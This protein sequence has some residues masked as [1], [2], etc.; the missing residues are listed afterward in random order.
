MQVTET[1]SDG[2][3][4][5]YSVVLPAADIETR[6]AERLTT[7]SKTMRLPGFRPG[8]VPM[9]IIRQ[10]FGTSVSAEVLEESVSEATRQVLT[11][12]GLRPAL[13]PKVEI[14]TDDPT[15]AIV[16]D[17]EFKV[18]MEL[19]PDI[20]LPDFGAIELT[21]KKVAVGE[22]MIAES[23]AAIAKSR[24]VLEDYTAEEIAERGGSL[25]GRTGD[26]LIV[27]YIGKIDG[28]AF[29]GGTANDAEI[30]LGG[31]GFI[32]GFVEQLEGVTVGE[33]RTINVT[34]PEGYSAT[35]LAGKPATFDITVKQIRKPVAAPLDDDFAMKIGYDTLE[36]LRED[37]RTRRQADFDGLSRMRVKRLLL[38]N[39]AG[40]VTFPLPPTIAEQEF[41]QIWERLEA[42][43]K[44][45]ELDDDDK[46]KDDDTLK[47]E[48]RA[49]GDRRVRL[50]LLLA[51]IARLNSLTVNE[52]E[53]ARAI[54]QE[55]MRYPGQEES[56]MEL[57]R[58]YPALADNLRAPI[59]EDKVVDF[60]LEL[61]KITDE[62][63]TVEELLKEPP[64]GTSAAAATE[65]PATGDA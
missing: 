61:A 49:I 5:A 41:N 7:L 28:E 34:F 16:R 27:D 33:A 10:R 43:R 44:S 48:Y 36:E 42:S 64:P 1:L 14:V 8:K 52:N 21:R 11:D 55:A 40:S 53:L 6:R 54:R 57:F 39:L 46:G 20:P 35:E 4:R 23:L 15:A 29:D 63:V 51:E 26:V 9:P 56:M 47:A 38:D 37:I 24:R 30:E 60:I 17:I 65:T 50:G 58:K 59:L 22:E 62:I 18:E 32:P 31:D 19:L 25:S 12:R 2:L 13:Q 45:G 3:R